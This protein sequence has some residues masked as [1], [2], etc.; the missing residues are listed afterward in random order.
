MVEELPVKHLIRFEFATV[1]HERKEARQTSLAR[2]F[3]G[4]Y[5]RLFVR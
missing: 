5:G 3:L 4:S 1:E 2:L